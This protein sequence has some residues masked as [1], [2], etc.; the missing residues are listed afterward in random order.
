MEVSGGTG[1][2]KSNCDPFSRPARRSS[3]RHISRLDIGFAIHR[4]RNEIGEAE[5]QK[6]VSHTKVLV[7][8]VQKV[9]IWPL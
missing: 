8:I 2:K 6:N 3:I 9:G 7:Y 1:N 5:R 4:W